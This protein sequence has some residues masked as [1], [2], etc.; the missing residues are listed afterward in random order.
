MSEFRMQQLEL[1]VDEWIS[2]MKEKRDIRYIAHKNGAVTEKELRLYTGFLMTTKAF[3]LEEAGRQDI[4][5]ERVSDVYVNQKAYRFLAS[6]IGRDVVELKQEIADIYNKIL[7][8][9]MM[10]NRMN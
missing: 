5:V 2:Q 8:Y 9:V 7:P 10:Q 3:F 4:P 1:A 6:V